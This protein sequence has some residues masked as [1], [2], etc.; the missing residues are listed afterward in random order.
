MVIL[1]SLDF[2]RNGGQVAEVVIFTSI[3]DGFEVFRISP[4][5]DAD[6]GDL[7]LFCHI[8]CLL[9]LYNGIIGKLIPGNSAAFFYQPDDN[10]W[11][12]DYNEQ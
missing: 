11:Y 6:T 10:F 8:Y 3:G 1:L 12:G 7:A 4:V 2:W 9:F 5:G